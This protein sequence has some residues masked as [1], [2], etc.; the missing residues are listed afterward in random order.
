M[1]WIEVVLRYIHVV[2]GFA[3]LAA[4]WVPVFS[5]KGGKRHILFGRIFVF[6]AWVVLVSAMAAV[7]YFVAVLTAAGESPRTEPVNYSF[8]IFLFYLAVVTLI[9][10]RHA[11][12]VLKTKA[13]PE[14]LRTP[15]NL[16]AANLAG[17][18]SIV[19]VAYALF[20]RP[21][22]LI[23]LLALSPIGFS[24]RQGNLRYLNGPRSS[25]REWFYEHMGAMLGA[26]IA[27]H[28]AFLVFGSRR[29]FDWSLQGWLAVVPWILPAAIGVPATVIWRRRYRRKFGEL[30]G[31]AQ[32]TTG[33]PAA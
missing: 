26:G 4:W 18:A 25:P 7:V 5:K 17:I 1:E 10:V 29:L 15:F 32:P 21:P 27:F 16:A 28:T 23:L 11:V 12:G 13:D 19:L 3:G 33:S 30:P 22:T 8:L 6:S 24:V 9:I 2:F 14:A 31:P 20:F